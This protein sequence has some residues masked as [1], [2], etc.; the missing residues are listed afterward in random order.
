MTVFSLPKF[1][2]KVT[3]HTKKIQILELPN[4][5]FKITTLKVLNE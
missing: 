3:K 1:Q 2:Q 4:K 5:E